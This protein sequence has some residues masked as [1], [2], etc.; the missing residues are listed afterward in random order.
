MFT[1]EVFVKDD[2]KLNAI[3]SG[4]SDSK[5]AILKAKN[6]YQTKIDLFD[7]REYVLSKLRI[8]P[9]VAARNL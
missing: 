6:D 9:M 1:F 3:S 7:N 8:L 2:F 4:V 5:E